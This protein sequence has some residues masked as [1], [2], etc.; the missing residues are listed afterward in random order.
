MAG[1]LRRLITRA[2]W[3]DAMS[4]PERVVC[5]EWFVHSGGSDQV[6]AQLARLV[7]AEVVYTFALDESFASRLFHQHGVTAPVVTWRFGRSIGRRS[8]LLLAIMP[9][10]WKALDLRSAR[11]VVTSS[12]AC[13]N[14]VAAP[15][16]LSYC[17]TPMRY[18]WEW[19]LERDRLPRWAQPGMP[20]V[21]AV[22]RLL[23]RRW[24]RSVEVHVA[25][26]HF[27]AERIRRAYGV[28]AIVI[29]PPVE[30]TRFA[31][32]PRP[33]AVGPFLAAGRFVPYKRFD[34]AIEAAN[35][36][37]V[38]LVVAGDG[39]ER[40][41]LLRLAGPTVR[42]DIGPDDERL[43]QLL[44]SARALV[45]CGVE[46]FGMLPV[47][48]QAAGT[49]VIARGLGGATESV[50]HGRTGILVDSDRTE[51][52]AAALTSFDPAEFDVDVL[53]AHAATFGSERFAA[54]LLDPLCAPGAFI[55]R[56]AR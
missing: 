46:D 49:P 3:P 51:D 1:R 22:F 32:R 50:V 23:D 17:H 8:A 44:T 52:W 4:D 20:I 42:F 5:H 37:G 27:V 30:V 21:A 28:D 9:L 47:E 14:A 12:H 54:R 7:E 53:R 48:A 38:E 24:A 25:N 39:P 6:A 19:R 41:R 55:A 33:V 26:S 45:F 35:R 2:V 34:L 16:H 40:E 13:V 36:A 31:E 29:P 56:H 43:A 18:A 11:L 10:V 15:H